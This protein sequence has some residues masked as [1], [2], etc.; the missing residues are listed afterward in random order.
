[1]SEPMRYGIV[2]VDHGSRRA[3]SNELLELVAS[4]FARRFTERYEIVE[5]AHMELA[6]PSIATAFG[7]CVERGARRVVVCPFFLCPCKH[8]TGD[9]PRL[10]AEAAAKHPGTTYHVTM[11]LGIDDLI[12]QLID[13]RIGHCVGS[14]FLCDNCRGSIRSGEP[15][16][17]AALL[18]GELPGAATAAHG[19]NG[20][21]QAASNEPQICSTC[22][23]AKALAEGAT[24][25]PA[26]G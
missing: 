6:E 16:I 4:E 20:N 13:K 5:P 12:L 3:P 14:G 9:I 8:W 15:E 11:P 21:G 19:A 18:R 10:A 2:I 22:P 7:R 25:V 24:L 23:Y 26:G 17:A 1:M